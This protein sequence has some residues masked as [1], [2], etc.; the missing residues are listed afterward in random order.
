VFVAF[1]SVCSAQ[2]STNFRMDRITVASGAE[3]IASANFA[4]SVTF[5]QEGPV[6]SVSRC[7]DGLLQTAGFWS[8]SGHTPVPV[9]LHVGRAASDPSL[10][11]L[12]WSGS[13]PEFTLYRSVIPQ[14]VVNPLNQTLVTTGC[15][16]IDTPPPAAVIYYVVQPGGD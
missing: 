7:N 13:S 12:S 9:R 2:S 3:P 10:P 5:A 15:S 6:G 16:T 1:A 8:M 14:G 4:M 11:E